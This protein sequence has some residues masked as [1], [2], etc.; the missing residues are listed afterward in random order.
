ML[1]FLTSFKI[2]TVVFSINIILAIST[3][4]SPRNLLTF[5]ICSAKTGKSTILN[6]TL[7]YLFNITVQYRRK[8]LSR[9]QR[10][11][12]VSVIQFCLYGDDTNWVFSAT[13]LNSARYFLINI[14][15]LLFYY[16][17]MIIHSCVWAVY[18]TAIRGE[19]AMTWYSLIIFRR[20]FVLADLA[21]P[22]CIFLLACA[23]W[24][25]SEGDMTLVLRE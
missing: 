1:F 13:C 22:L 11:W 14:V 21:N 3:K 10:T 18:R 5:I 12:C 19:V 2:H 23:L 20:W 25:N 9:L 17:W 8:V 15:I 16:F 6:I 4:N 24:F 7:V